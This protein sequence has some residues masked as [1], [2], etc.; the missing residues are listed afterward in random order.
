MKIGF[1]FVGKTGNREI[2]K[3]ISSYL[4][5]LSRFVQVEN[6]IVRAEKITPSKT[7]ESILQSEGKRI[8]EAMEAS[9]YVVVWD[10][11][12]TMISSGEYA[13]IL[14][15]WEMEGRK[16]IWMVTGGP[17][18]VSPSV[19]NHAHETFSLSP[20]VFPHD[21]VRVIILEQTYRAF[22]IIRNMP[23]HK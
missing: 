8:L 10:A 3:L 12:G 16:K 17:I 6:K 2:D 1:V 23:Y 5:R 14:A 22:T 13:N 7:E 15:R 18:G 20:M 11:K 4:Q 21:L 9:D 19:I